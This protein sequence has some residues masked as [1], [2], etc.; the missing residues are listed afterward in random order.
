MATLNLVTN[1]G[2]SEHL[3]SECQKK[4]K[5]AIEKWEEKSI[6]GRTKVRENWP[7]VGWAWNSVWWRVVDKKDRGKK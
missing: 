3:R 2:P 7:N 1:N 5:V 4:K 6:L